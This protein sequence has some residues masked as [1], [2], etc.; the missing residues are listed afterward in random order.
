MI[1][2]LQDLTNAMLLW[3]LGTFF[4]LSPQPVQQQWDG[5][6]LLE[7]PGCER[8]IEQ[9]SDTRSLP[10]QFSVAVWNVYK[11][12]RDG[13]YNR[14]TQLANQSDLLLLQEAVG[15]AVLPAHLED[16][17]WHLHQAFRKDDLAVGVMTASRVEP[18]QLCGEQFIEPWLGL[19]KTLLITRYALPETDQSLLVINLHAVN[20]TLGIDDYQAQLQQIR[21]VADAHAGPLLLAGDF[22]SWN[23]DRQ[24]ALQATARAL[25][26]QA[27]VYA[28]D[29]RSTM[30]GHA[31]DGI[32]VRGLQTQSAEVLFTPSSDHN[33]LIAR[34]S[35]LP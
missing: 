7:L 27:V 4:A 20:F 5:Q 34:F 25:A 12:R 13:S 9:R 15:T 23:G 11:W 10:A 24:Q 30:F 3:L 28:D 6:Q 33:A 31:L 8:L 16:F 21:S 14:L 17:Q 1:E 2:S 19:P 32:W 22:N 26:L 18:L 29:K 35:Y